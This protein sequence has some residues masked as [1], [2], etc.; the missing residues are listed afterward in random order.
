MVRNAVQFVTGV[1]AVLIG[2]AAIGLGLV[3]YGVDSSLWLLTFGTTVL[4][5]L[6][7]FVWGGRTV[8]SVL[9]V[10]RLTVSIERNG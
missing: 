7:L 5:G 1:A 9:P 3:H 2:G 10:P 6:T 8:L 4:V